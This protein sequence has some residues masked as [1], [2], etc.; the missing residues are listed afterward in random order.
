MTSFA[1]TFPFATC[2]QPVALQLY[3]PILLSFKPE[4]VRIMILRS[5]TVG[6]TSGEL[7]I[8]T[9][10]GFPLAVLLLLLKDKRPIPAEAT[11]MS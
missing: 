2:W 10:V 1:F 9:T 5:C 4:A 7:Q 8:I 3:F 6:P 11:N